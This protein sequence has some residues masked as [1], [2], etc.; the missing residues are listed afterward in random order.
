MSTPTKDK[1]N[2]LRRRDVPEH[3]I[4]QVLGTTEKQLRRIAGKR[5]PGR[6][7]TELAWVEWVKRYPGLSLEEA[8][9]HLRISYTKLRRAVHRHAG[10]DFISAHS[11]RRGF[12]ATSAIVAEFVAGSRRPFTTKYINGWRK[13]L[14]NRMLHYMSLAEWAKLFKIEQ[15]DRGTRLPVVK[16]GDV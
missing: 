15:I 8:A 9:G 12:E 1:I 7:E 6:L 14:V 13:G 5:T 16:E 3:E 2:L 4:T 11:K 10:D